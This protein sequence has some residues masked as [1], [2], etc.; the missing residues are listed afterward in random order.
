PVREGSVAM[1]G[2]FI[3]THVICTMTALTI[4]VTETH[5]DP[6]LAGMGAQITAAAFGKLHSIMPYLLTVATIIFAYSTI[7]SWSY[8][9]EKAW[10][11]LFGKKTI[12]IYRLIYI[13]IVIAGPIVSIQNVIDFSDL[14]L[15]S[16]AFPN[17]IGMM[18][19]SGK[20]KRLTIEYIHNLKEG[21]FKVFK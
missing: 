1:I 7:I 19:M 12:M 16:M 11:F 4:L 5:L 14:M 13:F 17:I 9:G 3:D 18:F 8:Y 20:V 6:S 21:Q 2:P 10:H 15:L